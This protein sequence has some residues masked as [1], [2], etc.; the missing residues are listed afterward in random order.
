MV[1]QVKKAIRDTMKQI[2]SKISLSYRA[3]ASNQICARIRTLEQYRYAKKIALYFAINNEI[4]LDGIWSSAPLQGKFCYFPAINQDN[5]TLSF[6]PATPATP[7]KKNRFGI[8]E[9]DVSFDL[10]IPV[11]ELDLILMPLVAFDVRCTRL[12]MGAGFYDRTFKNK[13]NCTL[14]GVAYQFQRVD[15]IQTH[16]WDIPLDAVITQRAI[17]W[18]NLS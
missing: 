8:P 17:Y 12:G 1:D 18:R 9:P 3:T 16:P 7:F 5:L 4:D 15:Y 2:R 10:A 14:F 13:T 6:L 11:E